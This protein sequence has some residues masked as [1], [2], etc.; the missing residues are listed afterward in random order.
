M[1]NQATKTTSNDTKFEPLREGTYEG[2]AVNHRAAIVGPIPPTDETHER[3]R[4][5]DLRPGDWVVSTLL[6]ERKP[7][8]AFESG[9]G[10]GLRS[11]ESLR[12]PLRT[13]GREM[14]VEGRV[15][16]IVYAGRRI[17]TVESEIRDERPDGVTLD[18]GSA[19]ALT[20]TG[21]EAL[22]LVSEYWMPIDFV[23]CRLVV[24]GDKAG[25]DD[26]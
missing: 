8:A 16:V 15:R 9:R 13:P 5:R 12:K 2:S 11:V 19:W 22:F 14:Y 23:G 1:N 21:W 26:R 25:R 10:G 24:S 20:R 4:G 3:I 7:G 6:V 17:A 18:L